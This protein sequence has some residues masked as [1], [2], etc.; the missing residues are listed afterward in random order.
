MPLNKTNSAFV[1]IEKIN[2][3]T[4]QSAAGSSKKNVR[5][6]FTSP[7]EMPHTQVGMGRLIVQGSLQA[8]SG[9]GMADVWV[10][11]PLWSPWFPSFS[12]AHFDECSLVLG[13]VATGI[14]FIS[15]GFDL[16]GD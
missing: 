16:I 4:L 6:Y 15:L 13:K 8:R 1:Y 10:R 12:K 7:T 2:T 9:P 5:N 14:R 11:L 3:A